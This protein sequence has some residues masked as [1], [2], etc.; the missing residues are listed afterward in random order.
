MEA[1][2]YLPHPD[3]RGHQRYNKSGQPVDGRLVNDTIRAEMLPWMECHLPARPR[4]LLDVGAGN[5]RLADIFCPL[6]E[7]VV[8]VEPDVKLDPRFDHDN[9]EWHDAGFERFWPGEPF[10]VI[11]FW[12]S[13]YIMAPWALRHAARMLLPDGCVLVVSDV[14]LDEE[15][16]LPKLAREAGLTWGERLDVKGGEFRAQLLGRGKR[17]D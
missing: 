12:G 10:D 9:L 17:V 1:N 16:D 7:T 13:F 3:G 14:C 4:R 5:G 15:Y 6:A 8:A 11:V 2:G